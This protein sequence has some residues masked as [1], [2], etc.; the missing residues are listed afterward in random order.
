MTR[1]TLSPEQAA[2]RLNEAGAPT[3]PS[4]VGR[5]CSKAGFGVAVM[6]GQH[7]T[8][9]GGRWRIPDENVATIEEQLLAAAR[10]SFVAL[11]RAGRPALKGANQNAP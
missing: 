1:K 6:N 11:P 2:A 10:H 9:A 7:D 8:G 4:S 3:T 5:W